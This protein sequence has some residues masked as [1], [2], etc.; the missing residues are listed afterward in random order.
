MYTARHLISNDL[1][2]LG[3]NSRQCLL[4]SGHVYITPQSPGVAKSSTRFSRA[5]QTVL[6]VYLK[7][8]SSRDT[9]ASSALGVPNEYAQYKSTH[10]L[11]HSLTSFGCGKGGNVTSVG[12]Q[13]ILC[14]PI[15]HVSSRCSET[16]C[17]LS[18]SVYLFT[19]PEWSH[20]RADWQR[21]E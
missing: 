18:H 9:S 12:W 1:V 2:T 20:L 21:L 11:T 4:F 19:I 13:V 6:G 3:S 7:R 15:W 16:G 8:T 14:D 17:K 10:T 5:A